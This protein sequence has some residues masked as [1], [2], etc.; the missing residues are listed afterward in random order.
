MCLNVHDVFLAF[1]LPSERHFILPW[2]NFSKQDETWSQFSTLEVAIC[3]L[4]TI[5]GVIN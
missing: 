5:Y 3:V 1:Y 4:N 2:T